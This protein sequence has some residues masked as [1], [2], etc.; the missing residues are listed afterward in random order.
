M[1]KKPRKS[2]QTLQSSSEELT[3]VDVVVPIF[4]QLDLAKEA[5]ASIKEAAPRTP[6]RLILVDDASEDQAVR[7]WIKETVPAGRRVFLKENQ[8]YAGAVNSGFKIGYAP[9][10]LILTSDVALYPDAIDTMVKVMDDPSVGVV[11]PTLLFPKGSKHGPPE[12]VQHAGIAFN[13]SG[14]PFHIFMGWTHTHP[15]VA[16]Q[17]DMQ[18]LTGACLL[19]RRNLFQELGGMNEIYGRGTFED[20]EYCF[21]VRSK[22]RRVVYEPS[23]IGTHSV[24][25]SA[26][27]AGGF[28][29]KRNESIFRAN[30]G[31]YI[32]WDEWRFW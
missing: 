30:V 15:K 31:Q 2:P 7:D 10:V 28:P 14:K 32:E 22:N 17:R 18:A 8:G 26:L 25:A 20:M 24:G 5:V 19:T 12:R 1:R 6:W 3:L 29:L 16:K 4:N 21:L 27:P 9:L 13:M 11:G 23:A